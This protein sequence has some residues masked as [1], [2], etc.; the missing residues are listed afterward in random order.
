M[1][2]TIAHEWRKARTEHR[3]IWCGEKIESGEYYFHWRGIFEGNISS[4]DW[5][6]ECNAA[7]DSVDLHDGFEPHFHKR[8]SQEER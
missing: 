8:G 4:N 2:I 1:T 6:K 3:C 7:A 5:H